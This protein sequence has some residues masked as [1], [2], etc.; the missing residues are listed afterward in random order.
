MRCLLFSLGGPDDLVLVVVVDVRAY[1]HD[2][3]RGVVCTSELVVELKLR[4]G[5]LPLLAVVVEHVFALIVGN[6][7]T[8][9]SVDHSCHSLLRGIICIG[10]L[11]ELE[12]MSIQDC[13]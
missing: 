6:I 3:I 10:T 12:Q 13:P 2:I 11:V 4:R 7:N 8:L 1:R 5:I 9:Q